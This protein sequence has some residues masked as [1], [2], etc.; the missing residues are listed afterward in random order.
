MSRA[1][2]SDVDFTAVV[3][4]SVMALLMEKCQLEAQ[5]AGLARRFDTVLE[6]NKRLEQQLAGA[7]LR[8]PRETSNEAIAGWRPRTLRA[9][10]GMAVQYFREVNSLAAGIAQIDYFLLLK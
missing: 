7:G 10:I 3:K 4:A 2:S 1:A 9:H 6:R 5:N 8:P